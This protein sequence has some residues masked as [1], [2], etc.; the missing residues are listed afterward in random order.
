MLPTPVNAALTPTALSS[1]SSPS[2][3]DKTLH[4]EH[5]ALR[6]Q[7]P[8]AQVSLQDEVSAS[9]AWP[10]LP[11]CSPRL[12]TFAPTPARHMTQAQ[13]HPELSHLACQMWLYLQ[14]SSPSAPI[15]AVATSSGSQDTAPTRA[16]IVTSGLGL[17]NPTPLSGPARTPHSRCTPPG[18]ASCQPQRL[19]HL[20][21]DPRSRAHDHL[22]ALARTALSVRMLFLHISA[23]Q[24]LILQPPLKCHPYIPGT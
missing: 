14:P 4:L 9:P 21:G 7:T 2:H 15:P 12:C 8:E 6:P 5:S 17:P 10:H 16:P 13:S 19:P 11:N 1:P 23:W 22:K 24:P 20:C 3:A 18:S